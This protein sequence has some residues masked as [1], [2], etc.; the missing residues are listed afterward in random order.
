MSPDTEVAKSTAPVRATGGRRT[1]LQLILAVWLL[2]GA[3]LIGVIVFG[4]YSGVPTEDLSEA[5]F[6]KSH[7]IS[8]PLALFW[9]TISTMILPRLFQT[10]FAAK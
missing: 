10:L 7:V 4:G 3:V 9:I 6:T 1:L 5:S 2:A 8:G